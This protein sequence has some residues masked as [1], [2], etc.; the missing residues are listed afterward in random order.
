VPIYDQSN[1]LLAMRTTLDGY[2]AILTELDGEDRLSAPF[3]YR[4]RFATE[5]PVAAVKALIGTEV[6]LYFGQPGPEV[7][8]LVARRPLNGRFRR[9]ARAGRIGRDGTVLEWE[10]E[11]VPALWFLSQTS[12]FRIFHDQTIPQI[13]A[14]ILN[15]QGILFSDRIVVPEAYGTLEY[16]VQYD[17]TALDFVSRL[18]EHAGIFY[19]HE[20]TEVAHTLCFTD[21]NNNVRIP[22][23]S[24]D[25]MAPGD[26]VLEHV[27]EAY[28]FRT[29][30][31]TVRDHNLTRPQRAW[32]KT[33]RFAGVAGADA[34]VVQQFTRLE[35]YRYP[36]NYMARLRS[37]GGGSSVGQ[38]GQ[39]DADLM[40]TRLVEIE[41][42]HWE[43]WSGAGLAAALDAGTKV[44]LQPDTEAD[45]ADYLITAIRHR[46]Q[47]HSNWTEAEW[48]LR[49]PG[50][51]AA[52]VPSCV[53][54]FDC[55]P[56]AVPFRPD[57]VTPKPK[58]PGP[59][60]ALVVG[61][62][63]KDIDTDEYGRVKVQFQWD[64]APAGAPPV[65]TA[66][67]IRVSQGWAGGGWGQIH[68]PRVGQE[69]IVD[70]L[71][72]DPDRPIVTGRVYDAD[73]LP[74]YALPA[75]AAVSGIVT[76]ST[77]NGGT[78][79]YNELSFNDTKGSE[80][81]LLHAERDYVVEVENNETRT[82]G[83][84]GGV[85]NRTI[86]IKGNETVT[87]GGNRTVTVTGNAMDTIHGN[88]TRNVNGNVNETVGGTVTINVSGAVNVT[89]SDDINMTAKTIN[90]KSEKHNRTTTLY[91]WV[92]G[93]GCGSYYNIVN[94]IALFQT[95]SYGLVIN[96]NAISLTFNDVA[97]TVNV[98]SRTKDLI[99]DRKALLARENLDSEFK[100]SIMALDY[101]TTRLTRRVS[102]IE[103]HGV[104][105]MD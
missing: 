39:D 85:G 42:S 29:G 18:L 38:V 12:D 76:R 15:E 27:A 13:V 62:D 74:P 5:A 77:P 53:N 70:F 66:V 10:A 35:R 4:I 63:G 71:N 23:P 14:A 33:E 8:D 101:C 73:N 20:H 84:D 97:T 31:W 40:A 19:W 83:I 87:I 1:C 56:H 16:C 24:F 98:V 7:P 60:T 17:E 48:A 37:T 26:G 2:Q 58:V 103:R 65:T 3:V 78:D 93:P 99:V 21:N 94:S 52:P 86:A 44:H 61:D 28:S 89:A 25:T 81:V 102:S 36:G 51:G 41:E 67:P 6:T 91:D 34:A 64:R 80:Q 54:D 75:N 92:S 11:V 46:V 95:Y 69:V 32:D 72:G 79:N 45:A 43:R 105:V 55:V 59:Q 88:E 22:H 100:H 90:M 57:R 49:H 30:T 47:D 104:R 82:V 50:G 96:T 68:V 9:I